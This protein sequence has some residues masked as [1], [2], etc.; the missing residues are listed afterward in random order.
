MATRSELTSPCTRVYSADLHSSEEED[1]GNVTPSY[2]RQPQEQP[3]QNNDMLHPPPAACAPELNALLVDVAAQLTVEFE[4]TVNSWLPK[5]W[6]EKDATHVYKRRR[7]LCPTGPLPS[8]TLALMNELQPQAF[9]DSGFVSK[10]L[11]TNMELGRVLLANLCGLELHDQLLER[12]VKAATDEARRKQAG[13][14]RLSGKRARP[15]RHQSSQ[16]RPPE[17][18]DSE[19]AEPVD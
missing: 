4:E 15:T 6:W 16:V 14:S 3:E 11:Q 9:V 12:Y 5:G 18:S 8:A 7:A 19:S 13:P 17:D 1:N 10:Y 2:G